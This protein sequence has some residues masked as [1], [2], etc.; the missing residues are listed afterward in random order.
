MREAQQTA[1]PFYGD[2]API[3]ALATPPGESALA[4]IRCSGAGSLDLLAGIFSRPGALRAAGGHSIVHGWIRRGRCV[5]D[6]RDDRNGRNVQNDQNGASGD[7]AL[8]DEVLVS[9]YRAPGSYTGEEGADIVCHGGAATVKAVLAA[10]KTAGFREGL[11]GEFT[12]RAFI[13]GKIDLTRSESVMELVKAKTDTGREHAVGRLAGR[14]RGE[15]AALKQRLVEALAETE[16]HLD[17][18]EE[19]LGFS[20][21]QAGLPGREMVEKA[22]ERLRALA[23]TW[24]GERLYQEG[25]LAVIAGRPN[26]GKSSLFNA[27]LGEDRSIVTEIPGTTRDWIEA[28][29]CIGGIPLRLADTAGLRELAP[30]AEMDRAEELGIRRSRELLDQ[31]DLVLYVVD[32]TEGIREED[33][34][35]FRAQAALRRPLILLW[36]KA[37]LA[38]PA[39]PGAP[40]SPDSSVPPGFSAPLP[41]SAKTGEGLGELCR[42]IEEALG[43]GLPGRRAGETG[44]GSERQKELVDR[45]CAALEGALELADRG[46]P[47]ELA[48]PLLRDA[49]NAL[50]EITGEVSTADILET[51]FSKFCVGK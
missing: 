41:V 50:G 29:V 28:L 46:E 2:E 36:N 19:E 37:D 39:S 42:A 34:A 1:R 22:L 32:G 31:A 14:L 40:V 30:A 12:F 17:Y 15:I 47:L 44:L 25:A 18:D 20:G 6:S 9:V 13:N 10:L 7:S 21:E 49:V 11:P 24:G 4:L 35:V 48:A 23:D 8:I 3:S 51:I 26:A 38:P 43:R 45:S 27:L 16:L 5:R 33:E